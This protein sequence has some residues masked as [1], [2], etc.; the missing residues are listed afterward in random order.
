[1]VELSE[2]VLDQVDSIP[3]SSY[4]LETVCRVVP[5]FDLVCKNSVHVGNL[6]VFAR[7]H[8]DH[9]R[10][11]VEFFE[12][13]QGNRANFSTCLSRSHIRM[14]DGLLN[15]SGWSVGSQRA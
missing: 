8:L 15:L 14:K 7:I 11:I 13:F 9:D 6:G 1:M 4:F 2:V 10:D 3:D 5:Y 12:V